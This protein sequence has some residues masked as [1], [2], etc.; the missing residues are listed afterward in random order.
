[1]PSGKKHLSLNPSPEMPSGIKHLSLNP[2]PGG[3]GEQAFL[4]KRKAGSVPPISGEGFR[5]RCFAPQSRVSPSHPVDGFRERFFSPQ[6]FAP[7]GEG[8]RERCPINVKT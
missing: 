4:Q 8:F 6:G 3:E 5:E 2:S 7:P 1:M